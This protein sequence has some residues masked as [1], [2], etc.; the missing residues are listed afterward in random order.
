MA[1]WTKSYPAPRRVREMSEPERAWVGAFIDADG[2]V[3]ANNERRFNLRFPWS[4]SV[5]QKEVE[6]ISALLRAT[7]AGSVLYT[8]SRQDYVT[9]QSLGIWQW[10]LRRML[11]VIGLASQCILY[12]EKLQKVSQWC[13]DN[14]YIYVTKTHCQN[15]HL[16]EGDNIYVS[17]KGNRCCRPC[18]NA[19]LQAWREDRKQAKDL[20]VV[21]SDV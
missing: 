13:D 6:P 2:C 7:G 5:T 8:T 19:Y 4:V 18:R 12:S 14:P 9:R 11:D 15:G 3:S 17:P 21:K 1:D 16:Y 10:S 20:G